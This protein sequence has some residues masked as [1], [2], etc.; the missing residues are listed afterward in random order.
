MEKQKGQ[1][2][3]KNKEIIEE[4]QKAEIV[5]TDKIIEIG[6]GPGNLTKEIAKKAKKVLVFEIDKNFER[7]LNAVKE[8]NDNVEIFF[9]NAINFPWN[10]Y[11]KIVANIPYY[12]SDQI[13]Y[14][15]IEY[16][17]IK[18]II[19]VIGEKF[20]K[21]LLS[22]EKKSCV[23]ASLFYKIKPI[24]KIDKEDFYPAPKTDSWLVKL[25]R[26][27]P[28]DKAEK[29]LREVVKKRNKKIKNAIIDSFTEEGK[30]KRQ[31][32]EKVSELNLYE[33][34]LEKPVSRITGRLILR[35]KKEMQN[36]NI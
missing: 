31:A 21:S 4:V 24:K 7:D 34:I 9:G 30:T 13:I 12:L 18:K 1:H 6:A 14:K 15:A 35:L 10:G 5:K 20:K 29:I 3:L 36:R 27:K 28:S 19:L 22:K 8:E 26:K 2:I 32:K 11:N 23:I 33:N 17:E 16:E 25:E